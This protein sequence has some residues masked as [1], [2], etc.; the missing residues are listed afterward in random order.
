MDLKL[1]GKKALVTGSTA[2]IGLAIA[3][4]LAAEGADV[5]IN[6]RSEKR[7][8][9]AV[10]QIQKSAKSANAV[11][12]LAADLSTAEGAKVITDALP[13]IDILVNNMGIYEAKSFFDISDKDWLNMFETNVLSGIRLSRIYLPIMLKK[14]WGRII[15]ISSESGL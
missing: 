15:F 3:E 12:G 11:R 5:I 4:E 1:S 6:G 10:A 7:V 8:Q 13:E 14:N 9:E 2:G